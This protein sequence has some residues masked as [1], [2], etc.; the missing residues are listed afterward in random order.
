MYSFAD[1]V[2][3]AAAAGGTMEVAAAAAG[4]GGD[5][6]AG[7]ITGAGAEAWEAVGARA[8]CLGTYFT[9]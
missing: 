1:W 7:T 2:A 5:A 8:P 4:G 6:V 9:P 3:V